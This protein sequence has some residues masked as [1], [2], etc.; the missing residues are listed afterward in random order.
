MGVK[1][2]ERGYSSTQQMKK[3]MVEVEEPFRGVSKLKKILS[4]G[5]AVWPTYIIHKAPVCL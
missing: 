5:K 3:K 1:K 4:V 2:Q